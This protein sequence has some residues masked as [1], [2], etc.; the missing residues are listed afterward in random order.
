MAVG[1]VDGV[2]AIL[3]PAHLRN[4]TV[5][6]SDTSADKTQSRPEGQKRRDENAK[7]VVQ[8]EGNAK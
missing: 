4:R 8:D 7:Q 6:I 5:T 2:G 3:G 1:A